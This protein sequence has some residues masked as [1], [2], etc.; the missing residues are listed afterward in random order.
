MKEP[1]TRRELARYV[2][3][4]RVLIAL[5]LVL[6]I[7]C[8]VLT[9]QLVRKRP[10]TQG[11]STSSAGPEITASGSDVSNITSGP[12]A[13]G[14]KFSSKASGTAAQ[15]SSRNNGDESLAALADELDDWNLRLVNKSNPLPDG[16]TLK[17]AK[18]NASYARDVG[19]AYDARAVTKLNA[20]CAAAEADHIS[21]LVIS[22]FRTHARQTTLFQNQLAKVKANNPSLSEAEAEKKAATVSAYPGTSEHELGLAVDFNSVEETFEHT[23]QFNW[24]QSHAAEYGFVMRYPKSKESTTGVIYEPW[25]YRYVGERHAKKMNELGYCLEEYVEYLKQ[26]K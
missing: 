15:T 7:T 10:D 4:I 2:R 25:H 17:T 20:M 1:V 11:Q 12:D 6:A 9:W 3:T 5:V 18:I 13:S 14:E 22:S 16:Y 26:Y 8:G 19:M 23:A 24:L 21:L